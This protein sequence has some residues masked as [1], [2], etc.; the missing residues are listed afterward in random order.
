MF[1]N[2]PKNAAPRLHYLLCAPVLSFK[3]ILVSS[4]SNI[5]A[6]VDAKAEVSASSWQVLKKE[7]L[8]VKLSQHVCKGSRRR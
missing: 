7:T 2:Q 6:A 5:L 3:H 4:A 8:W 1:I